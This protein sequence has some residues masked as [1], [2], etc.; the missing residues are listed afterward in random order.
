MGNGTDNEEV[1]KVIGK[2]DGDGDGDGGMM[3]KPRRVL[4]LML[5]D[6]RRR[7]ANPEME[8]TLGNT[9][10]HPTAII[11]HCPKPRVTLLGIILYFDDGYAV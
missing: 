11:M 4:Y 8:T 9:R 2:R 3:G 7:S 1:I 6:T 5:K 10:L